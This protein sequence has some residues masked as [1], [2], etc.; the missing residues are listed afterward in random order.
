MAKKQNETQR[1]ML[2][3]AEDLARYGLEAVKIYF[4]T[5]TTHDAASADRAARCDKAIK[6]LS[7]Y[8]RIRASRANEMAIVLAAIKLGGTEAD[9]T[10]IIQRLIGQS[11]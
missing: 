7:A 10:V 1:T 3:E 9:G 8:S 11:E 5:P 4:S 6:L 2:V